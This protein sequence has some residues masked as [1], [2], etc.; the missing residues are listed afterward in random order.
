MLLW[1]LLKMTKIRYT[2]STIYKIV[3]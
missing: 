2:P 3:S 1:N